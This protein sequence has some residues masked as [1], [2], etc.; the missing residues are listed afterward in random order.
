MHIKTVTAARRLAPFLVAAVLLGAA[1]PARAFWLLNFGTAPPLPAGAVGFIGGTGGQLTEVGAPAQSSFTPFLAH[2]G[3]RVG[4]ASWVDAGFR[5]C[6]VALPF[7]AGGGPSLGGE[8]DVK[9]RLTPPRWKWQASVLAGAGYAYLLL[10]DQS[11]SAWS[12]GA[13][14]SV[15]R[16]LSARVTLTANARYAYT[17]IPTGTGGSDGNFVHSFGGSVGLRVAITNTIAVMPEVGAFGF[18][19]AIARATSNGWGLQYGVVLAARV[20]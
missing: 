11:K 2:A 4:L 19:G 3:I 18:E 20:R 7:Y 15:S 16:D 6:T 9:V 1:P 10:Q 8:L 12:P 5:L 13:E 14:L 17:A